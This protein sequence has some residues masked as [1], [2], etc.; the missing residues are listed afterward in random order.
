M[1]SDEQ[2]N[3]FTPAEL[4]VYRLWLSGEDLKNHYSR[5]TVWKYHTDILSKT[6][7]DIR[8][9]RRPEPNPA[10]NLAEILVPNNIVAIPEWA[11]GTPYYWA[12][13]TGFADDSEHLDRL[14]T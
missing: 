14:A 13:G 1:L 8:G 6:G 9:Y 11:Y 12:P 3:V 10:I 4:R 5:T 2:L 7:L